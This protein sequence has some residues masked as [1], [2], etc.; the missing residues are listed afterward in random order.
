MSRTVRFSSRAE[1]H[2]DNLYAFIEAESGASRADGFV[3]RIVDYCRGLEHF[4][5]R[6]MRRDDIRPALRILGYRRRVAIAF[7]VEPEH[8]TIIGV[9]YGG[10][11]YGAWLRKL[12]D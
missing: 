7:T 12:E 8:V 9:Y 5:E 10:R 4:P 2:L 3:S 6:G 11:N 1:R